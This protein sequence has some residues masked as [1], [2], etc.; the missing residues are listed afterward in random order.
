MKVKS[1][2][3]DARRS[4]GAGRP[5]IT[6]TREQLEALELLAGSI[7]R[8][9]VSKNAVLKLIAEAREGGGDIEGLEGKALGAIDRKLRTMIKRSK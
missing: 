4:R 8:G 6:W 2:I 3:K 7:R 1:L 9:E 5:K